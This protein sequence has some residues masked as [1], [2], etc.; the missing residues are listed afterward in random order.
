[1]SDS[2]ATLWT[3]SPQAP[4]SM[5]FSRQEYWSGLPCPPSGD[6]PNLRIKSM[7]LMS[8]ASARGSLPL[9]PPGLSE[10][11]ATLTLLP[12]CLWAGHHSDCPG[13]EGNFFSFT[14]ICREGALENPV[15]DTCQ[16]VTILMK[17]PEN[18][19][20]TCLQS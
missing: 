2:F 6:L 11:S 17:F 7:S 13:W 15:A 8:P 9:V 18:A 3:I 5:E 12:S 10:V 19:E 16:G 4:L 14:R 1:M 20:A